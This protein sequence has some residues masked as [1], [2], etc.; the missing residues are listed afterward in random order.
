MMRIPPNRL[1]KPFQAK[2]LELFCPQLRRPNVAWH[3]ATA[4]DK[5][6]APISAAISLP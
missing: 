2:F 6:E 1:L 3:L 4:A 5:H